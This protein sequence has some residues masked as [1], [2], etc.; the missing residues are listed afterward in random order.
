[1]RWNELPCVL[2]SGSSPPGPAGA[3][4][5]PIPASVSTHGGRGDVPSPPPPSDLPAVLKAEKF[6]KIVSPKMCL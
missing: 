2:K 1:M 5:L 4:S 6:R 3:V